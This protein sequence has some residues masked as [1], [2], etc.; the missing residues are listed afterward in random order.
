MSLVAAVHLL[1]GCIFLNSINIKIYIF[2]WNYTKSF[3]WVKMVAFASDCLKTLKKYP[4]CT[5][6]NFLFMIIQR[7][8]LSFVDSTQLT[9]PIHFNAFFLFN[10]VSFVLLF[11]FHVFTK[12]IN[13]NCSLGINTCFHH[14]LQL[15]GYVLN[16]NASY[17]DNNCN[18]R[19]SVMIEYKILT[20]VHV[21]MYNL[22][23]FT[24]F[25]C[26]NCQSRNFYL[27]TKFYI[28][29]IKFENAREHLKHFSFLLIFIKQRR[30]P[31]KSFDGREE[32]FHY[33]CLQ[34]EAQQ[35]ELKFQS[36]EFFRTSS[37]NLPETIPKLVSVAKLFLKCNFGALHLR[38]SI[39][40]LAFHVKNKTEFKAQKTFRR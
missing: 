33:I 29:W 20:I 6:L 23:S 28:R 14:Y 27:S 37:S 12:L 34:L 21:F 36:T 11:Y 39:L 7:I 3:S 22:D 24:G 4:Q 10:N 30:S 31:Q 35:S 2:C 17:I 26:V 15:F 19:P 32:S 5:Q 16:L 25:A 8:L 18:Q 38:N 9:F 13:N 40:K 1:R